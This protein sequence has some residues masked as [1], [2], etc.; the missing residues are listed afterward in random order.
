MASRG[1]HSSSRFD[2]AGIISALS[3]RTG[4]HIA[5]F[6]SLPTAQPHSVDDAS[7]YKH[8]DLELPEP[9]C[10]RQLIL[11][12][13]ARAPLPAPREEKDPPGQ[14]HRHLRHRCHR[15]SNLCSPSS[16]TSRSRRH[17]NH[18]SRL[19]AATMRLRHYHSHN[20]HRRRLHGPR[21]SVARRVQTRSTR[22]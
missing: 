16:L 8:I 4:C 9:D 17:T 12:C 6:F 15:P 14:R 11:L 13:A 22:T 1:K 20:L 2:R 21:P 7:L 3:L 5:D 10:T 19:H 18:T